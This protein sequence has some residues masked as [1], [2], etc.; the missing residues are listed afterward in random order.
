MPFFEKLG[1]EVGKELTIGV[2]KKTARRIQ[3]DFAGTEEQRALDRCFQQ[4][5][6]ELLEHVTFPEPDD[7]A[8]IESLLSSF[9][10]DEEVAIELNELL[11]GH[12]PDLSVLSERFK[13]SGYA[14]PLNLEPGFT[15]FVQAFVRAADEEEVLRSRIIVG[16][17]RKIHEEIIRQ[18]DEQK[19]H[20]EIL[21]GIDEKID[22]RLPDPKRDAE[23]ARAASLN[24]LFSDCQRL[25]IAFSGTDP[26]K[27]EVQLGDIFVDLNTRT[28]RV[29][30]DGQWE[31]HEATEDDPRLERRFPDAEKEQVP[32]REVVEADDALVVVLGDPGSGKSSFVKRWLAERLAS[33]LNGE[34]GPLPV[35]ITLRDLAPELR[36]L[37][38]PVQEDQR[39]KEL[40][41]AVVDHLC[42]Q[43]GGM[44]APV[45]EEVREINASGFEKRFRGC[46]G[47]GH[48]LL[49]ADGLD[50]VPQ[51]DRVRV[52]RAVQALLR[53]HPPMKAVVTCRIRSYTGD[54]RLEGARVCTLARFEPEQVSTFATVWYRSQAGVGRCKKAEVKARGEDLADKATRE[55]YDL[56][57]NPML[58]ATM[59]RVHLEDVTLPKERVKL[60]H[61]AVTLLLG[62]WRRSGSVPVSEGLQELLK[63]EEKVWPA[64]MRLAYEAHRTGAGG[65]KVADL[66]EGRALVILKNASCF[67]NVG[68]AE[69]FLRYVDERAGLLV[70]RGGPEGMEKV[71]TF[72]HRTF[73]EYL[74]G[75][76]VFDGRPCEVLNRLR[77][78]AAGGDTWR[79]AVELGVEE[80]HYRGGPDGLHKLLDVLY[81]IAE[82]EPENTANE[83]V[84]FWGGLIADKLGREVFSRDKGGRGEAKLDAFL[85]LLS[86]R[87]RGAL[88]TPERV[89]AG[90][91]LARLGD[92]RPEVIHPEATVFIHV[93]A[94]PFWMGEGDEGRGHRHRC[95]ALN[96]DY[97]IARFPV[98]VAQFRAFCEAKPFEPKDADSLRGPVNHP[99][100]WISW[101][102][103]RAYAAWLTE[104]LRAVAAERLQ[105]GRD[106]AERRLWQGLASGR[107]AVKLPS[108]AEWE[109]AAR[110]TE[111]RIYP[112]GD[113]SPDPER[114]NYRETRIWGTSA[115]G[116]FPQGAT[117]E[118]IEELAGNAWEWTRSLWGENLMESSFSYPYK[119][120]G[121]EDEAA[122]DNVRR[123]LRGGS[124][125]LNDRGVRCAIRHRDLPDARGLNCGFRVV[126][127]PFSEL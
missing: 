23:E 30:V 18:G 116:C 112:W 7:Q 51:A 89:R 53:I 32:V 84:I 20:T 47:S 11:R 63:Q 10:R 104:R 85:T 34:A 50:E 125:G 27:R 94:G 96:Y 65:R 67:G 106:E 120:D 101:H 87:V 117:P 60:Y 107:L 36:E 44:K 57:Q 105:E 46:I 95:E 3:N 123:V 100:V 115:V 91:I 80:R 90:N 41:R 99:V 6:N 22:S 12:P 102:E 121:R 114:A 61:R 81:E 124:F 28:F 103:A 17:L 1:L 56:A 31:E 92:P 21:Q 43:L 29:E 127:L 14:H 79:D 25:P 40:A 59:A 109:K 19:V 54:A 77:D 98:T 62:D 49:V 126:V 64:M 110:G 33:M 4:G 66:P 5:M 35:F 2:L 71:Y 8:A 111:G 93:S 58:L 55:H 9:A 74:A 45:G 82:I 75:C 37:A 52:R 42:R 69:A 70:G 13:A 72:P 88:T 78:L 26:V 119:R 24:A 86:G 15:A 76:R 83:R 118:G 113:E 122:P 97:W 108:E 48:Y 16:E 38:L 68:L 39:E 73:Q